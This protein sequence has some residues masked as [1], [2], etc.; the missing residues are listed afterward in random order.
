MKQIIITLESSEIQAIE[1]SGDKASIIK[2][3]LYSILVKYRI[4]SVER[5]RSCVHLFSD[6]Y[7]F[8]MYVV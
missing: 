2:V 6:M 4:D 1:K 7:C 8:R 5:F 3:N